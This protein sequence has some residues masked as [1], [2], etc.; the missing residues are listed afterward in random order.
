MQMNESLHPQKPLTEGE[1]DN[2]IAQSL[3]GIDDRV[4]VPDS[5]SASWRAAV[6]KQMLT[7]RINACLRYAAACA[8]CV[9]LVLVGKNLLA[10]NESQTDAA[11]TPY[12]ISE[13]AEAFN[14]LPGAVAYFADG[15]DAEEDTAIYVET[16]E[17]GANIIVR[18]TITVNAEQNQT[19]LLLSIINEYA[20]QYDGKLYVPQATAD[21]LKERI[22]VQAPDCD[23]IIS[24]EDVTEASDDAANELEKCISRIKA[25]EASDDDYALAET[26][27]VRMAEYERLREYAVVTVSVK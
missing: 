5:V 20:V 6:K 17:T 15:A 21:E 9:V 7:K 4:V 27:E 25:N 12:S 11:V 2:I 8:A 19:E 16:A 26:L 3:R 23:V 18:T 13:E 10:P 24:T 14:A 1:L 22:A